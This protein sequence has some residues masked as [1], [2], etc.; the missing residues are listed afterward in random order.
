MLLW[1]PLRSHKLPPAKL[2][3][4]GTLQSPRFTVLLRMHDPTIS[5][6]VRKLDD[7]MHADASRFTASRDYCTHVRSHNLISCQHC[8]TLKVQCSDAVNTSPGCRFTKVSSSRSR[9]GVSG[10]I[11]ERCVCTLASLRLWDPF[12]TRDRG[13][14]AVRCCRGLCAS[15]VTYPSWDAPYWRGTQLWLSYERN[16][17]FIQAPVASNQDAIECEPEDR[18]FSAVSLT[19]S[20]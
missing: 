19:M 2:E 11:P 6:R 8:M 10:R 9:R 17:P 5:L 7:T 3:A 15:W 1:V 4:P 12:R 13:R 20:F 18:D 16:S 14:C